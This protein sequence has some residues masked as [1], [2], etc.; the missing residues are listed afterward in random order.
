MKKSRFFWVPPRTWF[1][2]YKILRE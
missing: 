1:S 2:Y